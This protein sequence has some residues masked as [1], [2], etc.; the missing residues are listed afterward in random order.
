[1]SMSVNKQW[2]ASSVHGAASFITIT[3]STTILCAK[4]MHNQPLKLK[5]QEIGT[6]RFMIGYNRYII[7]MDLQR[8][9]T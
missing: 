8:S 1:M 9:A 4:P 3:L 5:S 7:H 6:Y 2:L